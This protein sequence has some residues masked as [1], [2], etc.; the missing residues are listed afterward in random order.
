MKFK[1]FNVVCEII[2]D[3]NTKGTHTIY[4]RK[5]KK[6]EEVDYL[7]KNYF[8]LDRPEI[9]FIRIIEVSEI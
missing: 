1:A 9:N 2:T 4:L 3:D 6:R 5:I 7:V 8:I